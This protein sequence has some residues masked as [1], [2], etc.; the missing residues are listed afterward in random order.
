MGCHCD[1]SSITNISKIKNAA[2]VN[3]RVCATIPIVVIFNLMLL[4]TEVAAGHLLYVPYKKLYPVT[5]FQIST[6]IKQEKQ[7]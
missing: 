2:E 1:L 5:Y 6:K 4:A 3:E 7:F